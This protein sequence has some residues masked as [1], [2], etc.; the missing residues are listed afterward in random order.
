MKRVSIL[1]L[2]LVLCFAGA[3]LAEEKKIDRGTILV[4]GGSSLG[5]LMGNHTIEPEGSDDIEASTTAFTLMGHGGYFLMDGLALGPIL[6]F[7]Y[8]QVKV[9]QEGL[10]T[11]GTLSMWEIGAQGVYIFNLGPRKTW[12]PFGALALEYLSGSMDYEV[13]SEAVNSDSSSEMS[14]WS[15]TPRGGI[16]F[17]LH[18]RIALDL[19]VY[20]KYI[21][22]SGS[23]DSGEQQDM[24]VTSMSYG[25]MLGIDGFLH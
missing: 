22:A 14:G 23:M 12:A 2:I 15:V 11:T 25:I 20:F 8:G 9:G 24:D 19:S 1:A 18:N 5:L 21:S 17:F 10:D 4:G 3:V 16:M 6:S 7:S 13:D